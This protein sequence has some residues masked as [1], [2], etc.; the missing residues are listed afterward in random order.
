M[1]PDNYSHH[2]N[3]DGP[4]RVLVHICSA[5]DRKRR[6]GRRRQRSPLLVRCFPSLD[7]QPSNR[8]FPG[9]E[10]GIGIALGKSPG[11]AARGHR[12]TRRVT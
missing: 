11:D 2:V 6:E 4:V 3:T 7:A 12:I 8:A 5:D 9:R 1:T 10:I